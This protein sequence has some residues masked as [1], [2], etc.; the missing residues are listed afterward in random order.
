M[1]SNKEKKG[2]FVIIAVMLT[3]IMIVSIGAIMH[4]AI[5]YYKHEPWEEYSTLLGDIEINSRRVVELSLADATNNDGNVS[6]LSG[7][8]AKWQNDLTGIYPSMGISLKS[9]GYQL[10]KGSNPT[11]KVTAFTLDIASIGL[12]GYTFSVEASLNLDIWQNSSVSPYNLAAIVKSE[13]GVAV[14]GLGVDNF[15]INGI[16]PKSV[17]PFFDEDT[18]TLMYRIEFEG[19]P[20]S[21]QVTDYRGIRAEVTSIPTR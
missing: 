20:T 12:E 15:K 16:S 7:N 21:A 8:L 11:A 2:Q 4:R 5:T 3:A 19:N 18:D 17:I 1:R 6:L 9:T 10:N 13:N 14:T